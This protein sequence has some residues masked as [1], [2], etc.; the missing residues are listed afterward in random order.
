LP[1][2][3]TLE[4]KCL[5]QDFPGTETQGVEEFSWKRRNS[6]SKEEKGSRGATRH[7]CSRD[8][9]S[10]GRGSGDRGLMITPQEASVRLEGIFQET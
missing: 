1:V 5:K 10:L 8:G 6:S 7:Q 2:L 9:R 4:P 3:K